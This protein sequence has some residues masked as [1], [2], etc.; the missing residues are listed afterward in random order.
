MLSRVLPE[1]SLQVNSLKITEIA[2]CCHVFFGESKA[3]LFTFLLIAS[4]FQSLFLA[5]WSVYFQSVP[6]VGRDLQQHCIRCNWK[7]TLYW[8]LP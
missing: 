2:E 1:M 8:C 4:R 7:K 3:S 6:E 5:H